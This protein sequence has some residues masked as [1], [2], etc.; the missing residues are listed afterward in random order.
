MSVTPASGRIRPVAEFT[1]PTL[2]ELS[3]RIDA[4][5]IFNFHPRW[6]CVG[7]GLGLQY[8]TGFETRSLLADFFEQSRPGLAGDW[9]LHKIVNGGSVDRHNVAIDLEERICL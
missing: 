1:I 2:V 4:N 8:R 3:R 9:F 7:A 6:S 5:F